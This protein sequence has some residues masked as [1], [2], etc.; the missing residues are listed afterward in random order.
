MVRESGRLAGRR[1]VRLGLLAVFVGALAT[2]PTVAAAGAGD[3]RG[4]I[5]EEPAWGRSSAPTPGVAEIKA[6]RGI[7]AHPPIKFSAI[8]I[9]G[10][11]AVPPRRFPSALMELP[12]DAARAVRLI[13]VPDCDGVRVAGLTLSGPAG[14][15]RLSHSDARGLAA[16]EDLVRIRDQ[17]VAVIR[18]DL[19]AIRGTEDHGAP[20]TDIAVDLSTTGAR[21]PVC[22]NAGPFTRACERGLVNYVASG[23]AAPSWTPPTGRATRTGTVTYC[24]S[25][26]DCQA[27][28]VDVLFIAAEDLAHSSGLMGLAVHH[29]VYLGLNIGIVD[30]GDLAELTPE[31]LHAFVQGVYTTR[32]AEHFGDGYLGFVLLVGDAYADDNQTVMIPTYDGYGG[33]E[34]ASDHYYACVSGDDDFADVMIGRF[35]VGTIREL[36]AVINKVVNYLPHDPLEDWYERVLLVA[37]MFY[38]SKDTYVALF[39][40]YQQLIPDD[41]SIDRIYR[42]DFGTTEECAQTVVDGF[43]AGY[44]FVNFA[45]DGWK[46]SWHLTMSTAHV[47][48]MQNFDRLPIVFS[49]A[50]MTGWFDNTTDQDAGG[51]Y[52]CLAEQMVNSSAGGAVA[53]L[54]ASRSSDGGIYTTITKKLYRAAFEEN[55]VFLG[56]MIA[57]AKLLHIQDGGDINYA[58]HF[59]LFGDPTLIFASDT[60]PAGLPDLVVRSHD[61]EWSSDFP[62]AGEDLSLTVP[63]RNQSQQPA[64]DVTVRISCTS[65]AGSYDVDAVIPSIDAWSIGTAEI[66]IPMPGVG[67]CAIEILVDPD[68]AIDELHEGNNSVVRG[69]YAYPHVAGFPVDLGA[70][71]HGPCAAHLGDAGG[72][73]VISD[74]DARLSAIAEDGSIAWQTPPAAGPL[75][76]DR[77]IAPAVGDLDG[78]GSAEIVFT[79]RMAISAVDPSGGELWTAPTQDPLGYPVLVDADV[80]GDLDV[81]ASTIGV[82]GAPCRIYA[83]DETGQ[84]IWSHDVP[85]SEDVSTSPVAGDFDLDGRPD[86]AYGTTGGRITALSCSQSPPVELWGPLDLGSSQIASLALGDIDGDGLLELV[87]ADESLVCVNA[88]D[89]SDV[90]WAAPIGPGVVSLALGDIDVDGVS[91]VLAGTS[92]GEL[93]LVAAGA[94]AWTAPLSGVPSESASVLDLDG[95]GHLEIL[96]GTDA[97]YLHVLNDQGQDYVPPIPIP[98]G[99]STPFAANLIGDGRREIVVSSDDGPVFAFSFE[100]GGSE[101]ALDWAGL[102]RSARRGGVHVQ[103]LGGTFTGDTVL[104]G[105]Y[106][107]TDDVFVDAGA[108]LT[109]ASESIFEFES[110]PPTRL[111]VDGTILARGHPDCEIVLTGE[112]AGSRFTWGGLVLGPGAVAD[113]ASC[114]VSGAA[115]GID[116]SLATVTVSD[117]EFTENGT[118]LRLN[119][120]TLDARSSAFSQSDS[121]GMYVEGGT[122]TVVGCTFD[123]NGAAGIECKDLGAYELR[124]SSF[125]GSVHGDGARLDRYSDVVIDSCVFDQNATS[126]IRVKTAAP[127]I[128]RSSLS[129]NGSY[130]VHCV[131]LADPEISWCT[132]SGNLIGVLSEAGSAPNLGNDFWPESGFNSFSSNQTAAIANYVS[133]SVPIYARRNYWGSPTPSGR[134]F[135]GYVAFVPWLSEPPDPEMYLVGAADLPTDFRLLRGAP[136]PFNPTTAI[137]YAVPAGTGHVEIAVFD[138]AGRRVA[139]LHSG[140][141]APGIHEVVWDGLDD[142]GNGVASG[143]YFVRMSAPDHSSSLRMTLLK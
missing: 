82:F 3:H 31:A 118:G 39:D 112:S 59:N 4:L 6:G 26:S 142:R 61:I 76:F 96:I 7:D 49:M 86:V 67:D 40:E 104:A 70:T 136:N 12:A 19:E 102:G 21:G 27:A 32:S 23:D 94:I 77:E 13:A 44:L 50:C 60:M 43:N 57:V 97:G 52:D 122:G 121:V 127:I 98:G 105:N 134:I 11:G 45:G 117:S 28:G 119:D 66:T 17:A 85:A 90:G 30:A 92:A 114:H 22:T 58:R 80:D 108:T 111:E 25:V 69:T 93:H 74:A 83:F 68:D 15:R 41:V 131:R 71:L 48:Q 79:K 110:D 47:P 106:R 116:A 143:V 1:L 115:V 113:L 135:I 75:P 84:P 10:A 132:I 34:V 133:T 9:D 5:E 65:G 37:G 130:G 42:H 89:G 53:C 24:H 99:C 140:A 18:F 107:V 8:H 54:A 46:F 29:A 72:H 141:C 73:V 125:T 2:P 103:P 81:V 35:S 56:E 33:T 138:I 36:A 126:G 38:T 109:I 137:T 87:V 78:D 139:T 128:T 64:D 95:D 55:C 20:W 100:A 124:G 51:S 91:E 88:E 16:V 63:V 123:S 14:S 120:C 62:G 129:D 101:R